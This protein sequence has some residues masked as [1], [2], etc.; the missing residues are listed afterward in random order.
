MNPLVKQAFALLLSYALASLLFTWIGHGGLLTPQTTL[1]PVVAVVGM[2]ALGLRLVVLFVVL[3]G[4]A[5][6]AVRWALQRWLPV[7]D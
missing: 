5:A 4:L 2:S 6:G 3:P 1:N 7:R